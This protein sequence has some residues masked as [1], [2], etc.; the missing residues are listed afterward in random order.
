MHHVVIGTAGHIDHGKTV[1]VKALTGIDCD[2]LPEEK[3]R[4]ITIDLGFAHMEEGDLQIHFVDVPGHERLV[5]TMIAGASGLDM[6]LLVVAADEGVMPQTRE[7]LEVIRLMGVPGGAVALT[8]ADLVDDEML[9]LAAEEV[10][11]LLDGTPFAGAP[12]VPV[13]ARTGRGIARLRRLLIEKAAE[14]RPHQTGDRPYRE[15][16]DRV[17]T[18]AGAGTVITGTSLWGTLREGDPVV[19]LPEGRRSRAR[20]LHVHGAERKKV[21]AGERVAINLAG[22]STDD[23]SRGDQVMCPGPWKVTRL[24]TANV[25]LLPSAPHALDEDEDVTLHLLATRIPA[26]VQRLSER[27]LR[28]GRTAVAQIGLAHPLLCFPG[29]RFVLRRPAPVNTFAGGMILDAHLPRFHRRDAARL[30]ELPSIDRSAWPAL[31][32]SWIV[33]SGLGAVTVP[34]LAGRLGVLDTAIEAALGRLLEGGK[35]RVLHTTPPRLAAVQHLERLAVTARETLR[36]RLA[37][38]EVSAGIPAR[39]FAASILPRAALQLADIYLEDLRQRGVL[40]IALGMVVPSGRRDHMTSKGEEL[41]HT[42]EKLYRDAALDPPS[43]QQVAATLQARPATVEG[44]CAFLVR[45]GRLV[46]LEGRLLIHAEALEEVRRSVLAWGV[47]SF[48]IAQFKER[49]GLTRRL[50][51][52]ILG[53]LDSNRVT[54]RQGSSRKVLARRG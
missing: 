8:K 28:P 11:T 12:V 14:V 48:D 22:L 10:R 29:D 33:G 36:R 32:E 31:L 53:W 40:D 25:E 4:G 24:V 15:A 23:V 27:P 42:I 43:P 18:M 19:V 16:I 35:I 45:R 38:Q 49:F 52:P 50:A 44:I 20:R 7:H 34:E 51:I 13:S 2:R 47:E 39:D 9:G 54:L 5:H 21:E 3:R 46:R 30:A 37:G 1:L 41:T 26:R 17:F 6:A